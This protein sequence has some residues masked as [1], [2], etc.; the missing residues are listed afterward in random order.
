MIAQV[1]GAFIGSAI[2]Y[3]IVSSGFA[4][5][6]TATGANDFAEGLLVPAI[7]AEVVGTF[8]FVLVVLGTTSET[9]TAP[10]FAGLVIGLTLVLI[11]IVCIP[12][13][14]T[15]VNPARSIAPAVFQGGTALSNLWVFI[16]GPFVGAALAAGV[17]KV[18]SCKNCENK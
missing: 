3:A 12:I 2:I 5:T 10:K 13:D 18:L 6:V 1:L 8:I 7:I 15:S 4:A 9:N 16:V 11:H 17:W 14:G